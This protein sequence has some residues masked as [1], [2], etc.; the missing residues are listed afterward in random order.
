[1]SILFMYICSFGIYRIFNW[2]I[3]LEY[4]ISLYSS[5]FPDHIIEN[6]HVFERHQSV[7]D[8]S[9]I[10]VVDLSIDWT[11][12]DALWYQWDLVL[13]DQNGQIVSRD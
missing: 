12:M 6:H 9:L 13:N 1:M 8:M 7:L 11:K 4:L 3:G 5:G 2:F 10:L